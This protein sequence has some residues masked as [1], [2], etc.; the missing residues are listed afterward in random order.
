[1]TIIGVVV[2]IRQYYFLVLFDLIG[3]AIALILSIRECRDYV[4]LRP[5]IFKFKTVKEVI[6]NISIGSKLTL[7]G[8]ATSLVIGILR[9]SIQMHWGI[10]VFAKIS[11]TLNISNII[12]I[13][14]NTIGQ[15]L[16]PILRTIDQ[17]KYKDIFNAMRE[18]LSLGLLI[19]LLGYFVASPVLTMWLPKYKD[20]LKY[21]AL[22]FPVY[23]FE[24]KS[25]LLY[26][27]FFKTIRKEKWVFIVNII[28][29][30]FCAVTV[31]IAVF[32]L[33]NLFLA[34]VFYV[35][36]AW[37]RN[38]ISDVLGSTYMQVHYFKSLALESIVLVIF[39][40]VAW[41]MNAVYGLVIYLITLCLYIVI[42]YR[43]IKESQ[44]FILPL[45][46]SK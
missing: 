46:S 5:A 1:M 43:S 2:G 40:T 33:D 13:F 17:S 20:G 12:M 24:S 34:V 36:A 21:M 22:L 41:S 30:V 27:A 23:V 29:L 6:E 25:A 38:I 3:K 28:S 11:F 39:M 16:F 19:I 37:L 15:V 45:I 14:V 32:F 8:L 35:L 7:G 18:L 9:Q 4:F 31:P 42:K 44:K 26:T 10:E